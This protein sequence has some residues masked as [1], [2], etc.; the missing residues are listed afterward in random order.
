MKKF[1]SALTAF[2]MCASMT[3]ASLPAS[4]LTMSDV[5]AITAADGTFTWYLDDTVFDPATED[6]AVLNVY[7]KNDPGTAG[8]DFTLLVDGKTFAD[9]GFEL[10]DIAWPEEGDSYKFGTFQPNMEIGCVGAANDKDGNITLPDGSVAV[11]YYVIPPA[12]AA[13]GTVY[14]LSLDELHAANES[15]E[16]H[17]TA[18]VDGTLTIKGGS[19]DPTETDPIDP[20]PGND[21]K[22]N[23]KE[24][25]W[26]ID[27]TYFDPE[28][29]EF[30]VL[31]VYVTKDIGISGFATEM[32]ADG[33][34][35]T[36]A[37]F[38]I[39]DITWPES[40][41]KYPFGTFQPN[42][43]RGGIGAAMDKEGD[44][45]TLPDGSIVVQYYVTPPADA[46]VGTVY[47]L[48]L[49]D[50]SVGNG[51]NEKFVPATID[52]S[53]TIGKKGDVDPTDPTETDPT[54]T[55]PTETD[56]T[57]TDPT[58]TDPIETEPPFEQESSE[59]P[60]FIWDIGEV[61]CE[62]G[63]TVTVP[64]T[65]EGNV[66]FNSY[67]AKIKADAGV[68]VGEPTDGKLGLGAIQFDAKTNTYGATDTA[69]GKNITANGDVFYMTYTVPED[70][71]P[72]TVY[73][74]TFDSIEVD[75]FEM[76][77]IIP[78]T[79]PGYIK[80]KEEETT[81]EPPFVEEEVEIDAE[82]II[83]TTEVEA[84][85]T[86]KL[87]ITVTGDKDGLNSYIAK[88]AVDAGPTATGAEAG[89]AYAALSFESN[90]A[91]MTFGATDTASGKNV[92]AADNSTVFYVTFDVP[93]DAAPGTLYNVKWADLTINNIEMQRL[94]PTKTDGWIKIKEDPT[95]TDPT[96]TD[97]TETDPTETDPTETDPT[98]TD[99]IETDPTETDPTGEDE[100]DPPYVP[101]EKAIDAEWIIGTTEVA[102]GA[103]V[104]LPVT[105]TGDVDGLNS[106]IAKLTADER[107]TATA[108]E[109]G[110][111]YNALAF[112]YNLAN[113]TFAAT[114]TDG[115]VAK[116]ADNAVV[117]YVTF[118][119]PAD[120]KN[121]DLF[122]VEWA[123]LEIMDSDM[124][125]LIP[126]KTNGWIKV[127][128]EDNV[129]LYEYQYTLNGQDKFYFAH[130]P[131]PFKDIY[132]DATLQRRGMMSDGTYTDWTTISLN[133]VD[134]F[135]VATVEG[136]YTNPK[137]AYDALG[138]AYCKVPL[139][140]TI[141]DHLPDGTAVEAVLTP[142]SETPFISNAIIGVKGDTNLDGTCAAD[143]AAEVL[144]YAAAYGAGEDAA[145]CNNADAITALGEEVCQ[146]FSYFLSDTDGENEE[147]DDTNSPVNA[148][149]AA[150]QLIFA[151]FEGAQ[152]V[153]TTKWAPDVLG[154][155]NLPQYTAAIY[156]WEQA[157]AA[158]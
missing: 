121:G 69:S 3:A 83:A 34:L 68:T 18:T 7:V 61:E 118:E 21:D 38:E 147:H 104:K 102:P 49:S 86:V 28:T 88:L 35:L 58:E 63:D 74:L 60:D 106:Y 85:A 129:T 133:A 32:L 16:R 84:G 150:N 27:D 13:P 52:G 57:E 26:Y 90:I 151:A 92:V 67:I 149:D 72:G 44:D 53:L 96:E 5:N 22:K 114:Y 117:F 8:F 135:I 39:L 48:S 66:G 155:D 23:A 158:E 139:K 146:N 81:T 110:S 122:P 89:D 9:A 143:D 71:A 153:G 76:V 127:V 95:E 51:N 24:F 64:V 17:T 56:P 157:N 137:A 105:V 75:N 134:E 11:Q 107:L 87:P 154:T 1:L 45:V 41:D 43:E 126:T 79:K 37:G 25:T 55:D 141:K 36:E 78:T 145:I 99:P 62:A 31:S 40:G 131:R 108:A 12:D 100:T 91:G 136:D 142:D 97:P 65:I 59:A 128:A 113:M 6:Y 93:A 112:E 77:K 119:V 80:V 124:V 20:N 144:I 111:A 42:M 156:A 70:A 94:I 2:C 152:G 46:A 123:D 30:A 15:Q 47:K 98:E 140:V 138:A 33:K 50:L 148:A 54:E 101:T 82:W 4:A 103:I 29:D 19:T 130:D 125:N 116:A 115:A 10:V 73:N 14:K 109:M 120:A 132:A